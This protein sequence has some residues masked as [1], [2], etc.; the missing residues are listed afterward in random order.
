MRG[1]CLSW[2]TGERRLHCRAL[3]ETPLPGQ[4]HLGQVLTDWHFPCRG[5]SLASRRPPASP[6]LPT[7][8]TVSVCNGRG[9]RRPLAGDIPRPALPGS[10]AGLESGPGSLDNNRLSCCYYLHISQKHKFETGLL[11]A[12]Q[13]LAGTAGS[14]APARLAA[15]PRPC[16][17]SVKSATPSAIQRTPRRDRE[18]APPA[19]S[20]RGGPCLLHA[21][22][23]FNSHT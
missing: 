11:L 14:R 4:A 7:G 1:S 12:P 3:D 13:E 6:C 10:L 18:V 16:L 2:L 23:I 9:Q 22:P 15:F 21:I 19:E 20:E 8:S 17:C 5:T